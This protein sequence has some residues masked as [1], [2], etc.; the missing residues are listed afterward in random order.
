MTEYRYPHFALEILLADLAFRGGPRPGERMPDFDL[1][2]TD[3]SR[4]RASDFVGRRP[5]LLT[6]ASITCPMAATAIPLLARLHDEFGARVAF[7]TLYVR[8]AHPGE[9]F[10][11]PDTFER[12]LE[13]A[14]A[15]HRLTAFPWPMAVDSIDGD[16]HQA[17]DP[18]SN[19]AYLMT[20]TGTVACRVLV[21]NH[22]QALREA[23]RVLVSATP[24]PIG[25]REPRV[26]PAVKA[27]G[28]MDEVLDLAGSIAKQD[29][30]REV[31]LGYALIRL[32]AVFR[33]LPPF[34]R[35]VAAIALST[36]GLV[37]V[38]AGL[39]RLLRGATSAAAQRAN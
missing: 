13:H 21:S 23:L 3:G 35:G 15:Y 10:P 27:I 9:H 34:G 4:V 22:E 12:K 24:H 25:Q 14:R 18:R 26:L 17:L 5:L 31:P 19:A 7:V 33:P 38:V 29:F 11:Q 1:A 2:T 20:T 37:V 28:V 8:E 6:C 36:I 39:R 30:R 16:L 32:A